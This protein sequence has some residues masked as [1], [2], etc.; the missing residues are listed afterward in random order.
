MM[1]RLHAGGF[2]QGS[3]HQRNWLVQPGPL[4]VAPVKRSVMRPSFRMIDFGRAACEKDVS[5]VDFKSKVNEENSRIRE[6][7]DYECHDHCPK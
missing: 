7:L 2:T 6:L 5:E 4:N 3:V 1:E